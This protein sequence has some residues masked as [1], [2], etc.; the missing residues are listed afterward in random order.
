VRAKGGKERARPL[1]HLLLEL[2]RDYIELE[3][4]DRFSTDAF[5]VVL[6]G[7]HRGEPMTA[8]GAA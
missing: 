6:Q 7:R 4:P 8:K 2:L 5:F 1:P 3:R